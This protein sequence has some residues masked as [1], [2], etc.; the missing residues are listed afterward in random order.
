MTT[1]KTTWVSEG[2]SD[3]FQRTIW[4]TTPS[5]TPATMA[6]GNDSIRATTAAA[7]AGKSTDGP[8]EISPG[9]TPLNGARSMNASVANPPAIIHTIIVLR[10][11]G[12]PRVR[13]RS[14]FSAAARTATP[15]SVRSKNHARPASSTGAMNKIS[16]SSPVSVLIPRST[17]TPIGTLKPA[18]SDTKSMAWLIPSSIPPSNCANPMLATVNTRREASRNRRST[19]TSMAAP[20]ATPASTPSGST[21]K[22][23]TPWAR[24]IPMALTPATLPIA[25]KAKFTKRLERYVRMIAAAPSAVTVPKMMPTRMMATGAT[26]ASHGPLPGRM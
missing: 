19:R 25:P 9:C 12:M 4:S 20:N 14:R 10:A 23:G 17:S 13:A 26:S 1:S 15:V 21:T 8:A 16:S 5:E 24:C 3:E 11:T 6:T 7:S 22:N 2:A 18:P